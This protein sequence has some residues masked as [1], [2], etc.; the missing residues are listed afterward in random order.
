MKFLK[1]QPV[2]FY[3]STFGY[4]VFK[5]YEIKIILNPE[6]SKILQKMLPE[7]IEQQD[8]IWTGIDEEDE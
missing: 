6:Q 7:L 8:Q 4:L 3:V 1:S 5:N 2:E